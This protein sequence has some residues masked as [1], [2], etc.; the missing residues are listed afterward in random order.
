MVQCEGQGCRSPQG[1][2]CCSF[3]DLGVWTLPLAQQVCPSQKYSW[4]PERTNYLDLILGKAVYGD[5]EL[6]DS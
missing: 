3:M 2:H 4:A 6:R 5:I 1:Q